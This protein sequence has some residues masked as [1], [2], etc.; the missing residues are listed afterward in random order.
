MNRIFSSTL[1]AL[2]IGLACAAFASDDGRGADA[3]KRQQAAGQ[4]QGQTGVPISSG[5][6]KP[7]SMEEAKKIIVARVNGT[8]ITKQ[9]L[10]NIMKRWRAREGA[11]AETPEGKASLRQKALQR[12]IFE[13]LAYQKATAEGLKAE[14]ADVDQSVADLRIKLGGP[15]KFEEFLKEEGL[16]EKE[17]R[18]D[19]ARGLVLQRIFKREIS[20][21]VTVSKEEI[22]RAY[23]KEKDKF[24][25]AEK[26]VVIDI[27]FFL[28]PEADASVRK[29]EKVL[30]M[31]QDEKDK[32]PMKLV[33]DGTFIAQEMELNKTKQKKLYKEAKKLKAGELSGIIKIDGSLHILKLKEYAP[34]RQFTL[35]DMK[36]YLEMSIG[37]QARL[38]RMHEWEKEL[39]KG[40]TIEILDS[41]ESTQVPAKAK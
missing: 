7:D 10:I 26:V 25:L 36:E 24:L 20:D 22:E 3:G 6:T 5:V 29:A 32:D 33:P 15:E 11:A 2:Y 13:E 12:L 17:M 31:I 9:S 28:D 35:D 39:R 14:P 4:V 18:S 40:A 19:V 23:E 41:G 1:V 16:S 8:D 34:E 38:Q 21:K 27:L 30:K 37:S